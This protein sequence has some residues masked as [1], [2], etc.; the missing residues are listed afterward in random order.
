[1]SE[2]HSPIYVFQPY[3][4][5]EETLEAIRQTLEVGWT[6]LGYK[7]VEIEEEWKKQ[8]KHQHAHFL[9]SASAAL[10]LALLVPKK[11]LNWRDGDEVISSPLTFV[12]TNHAI[13]QSGLSPVFADVDQFGCLDPEAV[14]R[15]ISPR[16]R[17]VIFVGLGGSTGQ[18]ERIAEL[19]RTRGLFLILDAAHMAGTTLHNSDPALFADV[20]CYSFQA[21]KN[22]PTADSGMVCFKSSSFDTAARRLSWLGISKDTYSRSDG[23]TY[24]WMYEVDDV[25]FKYNGNSI[26]A[27]MALVALKYLEDDN[28]RRR[29]IACMYSE[30]LSSME[31]IAEVPVPK[32]C[33]SSRH[34][35][36]ILVDDRDLALRTLHEHGVYPG[37]HYRTNTEY[38]VYRR[39]RGT[40]PRALKFSNTVLSLPL[41]LRLSN[42]DIARVI[43]AVGAYDRAVY[44]DTHG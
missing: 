33:T 34:L 27:A 10:H 24:A 39:W 8:F 26:M 28:E 36:Q 11:E 30:G 19:C 41:H 42:E 6:G 29:Q 4:R 37:V 43:D 18:L 15:A 12:S 35:F 16:T 20:S 22:L 9:N 7:T 31:A 32:G 44:R 13:L 3:Y 5:V 38:T 1:M 23:G 25:G 14:E 17:A 21:V 2:E 40:C